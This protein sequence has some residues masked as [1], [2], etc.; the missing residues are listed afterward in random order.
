MNK[1]EQKPK[2]MKLTVKTDISESLDKSKNVKKQ[3]IQK[4]EFTYKKQKT[5]KIIHMCKNL[6]ECDIDVISRKV[7]ELGI[8]KSYPDIN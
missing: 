3:E 2:K 4:E 1:K 6:D 8:N 7:S 5:K